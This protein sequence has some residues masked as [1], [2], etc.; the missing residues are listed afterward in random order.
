MG[1]E[2]FPL[3]I[4]GAFVS[5][6]AEWAHLSFRDKSWHVAF[7]FALAFVL[8]EYACSVTANR[9]LYGEYKGFLLQIVW[10]CSQQL[11]VNVYL[12]VFLKETYNWWHLGAV[13][14]LLAALGCAWLGT[15]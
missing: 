15:R 5:Q 9:A 3:L 6:V 11:A 8:L 1:T 13:V 7:F 14:F 12:Y 10:N 4:F 2:Y